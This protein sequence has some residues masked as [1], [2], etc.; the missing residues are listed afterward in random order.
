[1]ELSNPGCMAP[2]RIGEELERAETVHD[3]VGVIAAQDISQISIL[4][5]SHNRTELGDIQIKVF[6]SKGISQD[7]VIFVLPVTCACQN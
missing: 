3:G 1:M 4:Q 7:G 5:E 2:N 6:T